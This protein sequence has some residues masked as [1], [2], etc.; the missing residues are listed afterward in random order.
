MH[1][2]KFLIC[3]LFFY[4]RWKTTRIIFDKRKFKFS[5]SKMTPISSPFFKDVSM[6]Q[7]SKLFDKVKK[8][9]SI[10]TLISESKIHIL[11]LVISKEKWTPHTL[12]KNYTPHFKQTCST[13]ISSNFCP[14]LLS[15]LSCLR[16][17]ICFF[18]GT[19]QL[20]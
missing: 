15:I 7:V 5:N 1:L 17:M 16:L 4:R 8:T 3:S 11:W 13:L 9:V 2:Q 10:M 19:R 18:W 12:V 14:L 6:F 20:F